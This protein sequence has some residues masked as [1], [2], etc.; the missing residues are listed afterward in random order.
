M[1]L[2][3]RTIIHTIITA[4]SGIGM[5]LV[6]LCADNIGDIAQCGVFFAGTYLASKAFCIYLPN[7][8]KD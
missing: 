3:I 2:N 7:V 5:V 1:K 8:K 4:L 6:S